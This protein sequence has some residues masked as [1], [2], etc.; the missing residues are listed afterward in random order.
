MMGYLEGQEP[1][2][3]NQS[4]K[5]IEKFH[6][7]TWIRMASLLADEDDIWNLGFHFRIAYNTGNATR[8][9]SSKSSKASI[10]AVS[11]LQHR[12]GGYAL[13][14]VAGE[15]PSGQ[16]PVYVGGWLEVTTTRTTGRAFHHSQG[17]PGASSTCRRIWLLSSML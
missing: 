5:C 12:G 4:D 15:S 3:K 6:W 7:Q 11:E 14:G 8:E 9:L 17:A 16:T 10:E 2:Y 1:L 13:P